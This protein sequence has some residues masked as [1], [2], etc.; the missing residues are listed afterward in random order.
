MKISQ[1]KD[2]LRAI[3][4][5]KALDLSEKSYKFNL[6]VYR[7]IRSL[8]Q[9]RLY[10]LWLG[11]IEYET[12]NDKQY[13]HDIFR[14]QF[15]GFEDFEV[16]YPHSDVKRR[17]K[18][19]TG[20]DTLKFSEYLDKIKL[21]INTGFPEITLPDPNDKEFDRIIDYYSDIIE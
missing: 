2:K 3:E 17:L 18:S 7:E 14:E 5:I 4:Q 13:L 10:W 12:G 11:I 6:K 9:N 1:E 19:T 20:L 21:E 16:T 15:L 8:P